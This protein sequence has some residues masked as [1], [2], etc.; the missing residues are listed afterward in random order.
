MINQLF[1]GH[2][3]D[4]QHN[5]NNNNYYYYVPWPIIQYFISSKKNQ[6][7]IKFYFLRRL[8]VGLRDFIKWI[9]YAKYL[10]MYV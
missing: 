4:L 10:Y 7:F 9:S 6:D 8:G 1:C 3:D 5:E 2:N